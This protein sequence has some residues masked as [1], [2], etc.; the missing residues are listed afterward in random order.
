MYMDVWPNQMVGED[1][2]FCRREPN[3][4]YDRF[5]VSIVRNTIIDEFVVG[6]VMLSEVLS[7]FHSLPG[8]RIFFVV[9]K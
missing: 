1:S 8:S 4:R 5:A 3:N 2:L 9:K 6:H 7:K